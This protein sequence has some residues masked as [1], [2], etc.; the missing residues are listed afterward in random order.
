MSEPERRREGGEGCATQRAVERV[1][2]FFHTMVRRGVPR[3]EAQRAALSRALALFAEG[4]GVCPSILG[5]TSELP[6]DL[7]L[8]ITTA[9]RALLADAAREDWSSVHP[10]IFG[11]LLQRSMAS[12]RRH[13]LGAH[14][15]REA[16]IHKIVGPTIVEPFRARLAAAREPSALIALRAELGRYRVLDPACGTGNFLYVAYRELIRIEIEILRRLSPP[17]PGATAT[18]RSMSVGIEQLHGIDIDPFAVDLAR[19]TLLFAERLADAEIKAAW[20]RSPG[21]TGLD[22]P[23]PRS[24]GS[25]AA[26]LR[27]ADALF[28]AWPEVDAIIGNPP[29][30]S[31]NKLAIEYGPAY[32]ARLRERYPE[33]SGLS[34]YCVYWFRRAHDEL[35]PGGRAGLVG[36]NTIRQNTSREGG[37]DH[38]V[39][40]GTITEA[41][42]TQV[43]SGDASVHVSIV[44]WVKG[45]APGP[46]RLSFQEGADLM[47]SWRT[48]EV[49]FIPASLSVNADVTAAAALAENAV[50][51][52]CYQGQTH[53][54]EGLLVTPAE[55][56]A[57]MRARPENAEVLFPFLI[58]DDLLGRKDARPS[59]YVI[60]FHPRGLEEARAYEEPFERARALV[61]PSRR[62]AASAEEERNAALRS[63]RPRARVNQ[64]HHKFLGRWWLLSWPRPELMERLRALPR[65]I[66]CAR[67]TKRPVFAFVSAAI[68]PSDAL[69]VFALA[70]DYSF[71]IL[72]SM[73]HWAWFTERGSTLKGD[74]RYT[75]NTVFD[76]FPWPQDPGPGAVRLVAEAA[77]ALR[78]LRARILLAE[79]LCLR[80]LYRSL[81]LSG[82]PRLREAH[83]TL[84]ALVREAYGMKPDERAL[85]FL[86]E[87]NLSLAKLEA[88]GSRITG[89]GLPN[90]MAPRSSAFITA[91]CITPA[92]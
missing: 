83:A 5:A 17:E 77:A 63:Q 18:P 40:G 68:R 2:A 57:M 46:R 67:V 90:A 56:K 47:S 78:D 33:V 76:T 8:T 72:Q 87:L 26:N 19:L 35:L 25:F 10:A 91:D 41:V 50:S 79:G 48:V 73:V 81:E 89:P 53:G 54:H 4:I 61:L 13:A 49:P 20:S 75:S 85:A 1:V 55:A 3:R 45:D 69:Q 31:K 43:W 34:D 52:A 88:S 86:L 37:L 38:I 64:H 51:G 9:E 62:R 36:T 60:D 12:V 27:C 80:D 29:Y 21:L 84:D 23:R 30:Q 14:F 44:N 92:A 16:D 22:P 24:L 39:R 42:A 15:T 71:G 32:R 74:H 66:V 65:Y 59:R 82:H 6:A 11:E 28:C 7:S 70:D 58:A